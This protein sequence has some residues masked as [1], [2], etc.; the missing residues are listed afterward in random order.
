MRI[1]LIFD[2]KRCSLEDGPG[3]RTT[4]FLKGC[5]L[6]CFWCHNPEGKRPERQTA[7]FAEK[8]IGCG[9]CKGAMT[10]EVCPAQARKAYGKAYTQD[11]L[12]EILAADRPYYDAAGG[13]VTFSGGECMLYPEFVADMSK[14]CRQMGISVA[15][16]TAG[17][18]P[19]TA[20][21]QVLPYAALFLYD[22][23]CLDPALH[24]RG[25]GCDNGH[26]LQNLER[27]RETGRQ[28]MIRTPRIPGFNDGE[29]LARI[30]NFCR[31]RDLPWQVLPYH[32]FGEDKKKALQAA[33]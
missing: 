9:A 31:D 29:E 33:K 28:I 18:V 2:I 32:S 24:K 16:D 8:C 25:T 15:V 6:D 22:I 27:L 12:L 26:I 19:W 17:N 20:F 21:E 11:E 14:R 13:G 23:K 30:E 4:V 7:F 5:N 1:P 10:P 3:I